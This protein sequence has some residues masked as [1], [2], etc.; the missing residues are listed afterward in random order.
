MC[1]VQLY[2][3]SKT[4]R[5]N[6]QILWTWENFIQFTKCDCS[7]PTLPRLAH[8][9][10]SPDSLSHHAPWAPPELL[11]VFIIILWCRFI[12]VKTDKQKTLT[13]FNS[14]SDMAF[15]AGAFLATL[16]KAVHPFSAHTHCPFL[17]LWTLPSSYHS[18]IHYTLYLLC[19]FSVPTRV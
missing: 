18:L 5:K 4:E 1:L 12:H 7:L 9:L 10:L 2:P 8:L 16:S 6:F 17:A 15:S 13:S 11:L 19:L 14:C 3:K